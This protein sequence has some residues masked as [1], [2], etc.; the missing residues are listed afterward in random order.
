MLLRILFC[1]ATVNVYAQNTWKPP[2]QDVIIKTDFEIA[3]SLEKLKHF[4]KAVYF[5]SRAINLQEDT[6]D[7]YY[8]RGMLYA[9][10]NNYRAVIN[11]LHT[12]LEYIK[13]Q[14]YTRDKILGFDK[15]KGFTLDQVQIS[16]YMLGVCYLHFNETEKSCWHF[17]K[18]IEFGND[19]A[20]EIIKKHCN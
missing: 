15:M 6:I 17:T 3:D 12:Y 19:E 20:S 10:L 4:E 8:R 9:E 14:E 16:H 2:I 1:L 7:A 11:D 13:G 18:S 5:Y